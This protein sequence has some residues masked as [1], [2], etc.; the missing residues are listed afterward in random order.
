MLD[1]AFPAQISTLNTQSRKLEKHVRKSTSTFLHAAVD[2]FYAPR[3]QE[4]SIR[5]FFTFNFCNAFC[6]SLCKNRQPTIKLQRF[7]CGLATCAGLQPSHSY[8]L[9][10]HVWL[11]RECTRLCSQ[12]AQP[13]CSYGAALRSAAAPRG[14]AAY[15]ATL[16]L[17]HV[18][19]VTRL[20]TQRLNLPGTA[21][22][23]E[24]LFLL[25]AF[26]YTTSTPPAHSASHAVRALLELLS[27]FPPLRHFWSP[28][29][30]LA[31][32]LTRPFPL[33]GS[34]RPLRRGGATPP[35]PFRF[36]ASRHALY[37]FVSRI[38][39]WTTLWCTGFSHTVPRP[40]VVPAQ[41]APGRQCSPM[42]SARRIASLRCHASV[43]ISGAM[44]E[45]LYS[46]LRA[47]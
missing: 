42:R 34:C 10:R 43:F 40:C 37:F 8:R 5:T 11:G 3:L 36:Q 9:Q 32:D 29:H 18:K 46:S 33:H 19:I 25:D 30:L 31:A 45:R 21:Q 14:S 20:S 35:L 13:L 7:C 15:Y 17:Q 1:V 38:A 47:D 27:L 4:V 22:V 28:H 12:P 39:A 26:L 6:S 44:V 41:S 16:L 2:T 24:A 23:G